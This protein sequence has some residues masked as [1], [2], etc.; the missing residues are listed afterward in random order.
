MSQ[1]IPEEFLTTLGGN[2]THSYIASFGSFMRAVE[3]KA[4][5]RMIEYLGISELQLR[6]VDMKHL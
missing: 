3:E 6:F 1:P 5:F 4:I 2:Q